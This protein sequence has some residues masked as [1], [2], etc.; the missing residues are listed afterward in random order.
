MKHFSG[1]HKNNVLYLLIVVG[2]TFFCSADESTP[3]EPTDF[4]S[5]IYQ[6]SKTLAEAFALVQKKYF[7]QVNP[8]KALINSLNSFIHTLDPHSNFMDPKAYKEILETTQGEFCGIGV[9]I[10]NM[11]EP[12]QES[13]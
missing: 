7:Q 12:E 13:E 9:I 10:D 8:E 6:W 1:T 2:T 11:K 4:E 3:A 5:S